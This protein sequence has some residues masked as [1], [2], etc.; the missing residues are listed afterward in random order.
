MANYQP[1]ESRLV[2][3]LQTGTDESGKPKISS[4]SIGGINASASAD[5]IETVANTFA[6]LLSVPLYETRKEDTDSIVAE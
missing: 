3:R 1:V 5:D 4:K 6:G 2:L